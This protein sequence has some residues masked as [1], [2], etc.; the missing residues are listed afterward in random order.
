MYSTRRFSNQK[1]L[2]IKSIIRNKKIVV[3]KQAASLSYYHP[4]IS[5]T[6]ELIEENTCTKFDGCES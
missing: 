3:K 5:A 1:F 2:S 6:S 4:Y